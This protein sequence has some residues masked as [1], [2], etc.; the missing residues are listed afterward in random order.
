MSIW[1]VNFE[2]NIRKPDSKIFYFFCFVF[3]RIHF[4]GNHFEVKNRNW[5]GNIVQCLYFD[6]IKYNLISFYDQVTS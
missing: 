4:E 6:Y 2:K 1:Y 5:E 3:T